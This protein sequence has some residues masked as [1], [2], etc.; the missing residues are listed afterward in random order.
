[1]GFRNPNEE[2]IRLCGLKKAGPVMFLAGPD[3][4]CIVYTFNENLQPL[5]VKQF[6][7]LTHRNN[8]PKGVR[9]L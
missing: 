3:D 7:A 9:V 6:S 5:P 1:V 8:L 4:G 2:R